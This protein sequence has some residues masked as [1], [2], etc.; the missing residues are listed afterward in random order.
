RPHELHEVARGD[1]ERALVV[2]RAPVEIER[3]V[4]LL[5][6]DLVEV[7]RPDLVRHQRG[8]DGARAGAH[9]EIE[10]VGA[11]ARQGLVERR[12]RADLVH[13]ADDAAPGQHERPLGALTEPGPSTQ[14]V[15][16]HRYT[17]TIPRIW[18]AVAPETL[19]RLPSSSRH[20]LR[21]SARP[22]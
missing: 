16:E 9:V 8:H 21:R 19:E 15:P 12:D 14:G 6:E 5:V 17:L 1:T 13:A 20:R 2:D 3:I 4:P 10:L 22:V 18:V 7:E 11:E